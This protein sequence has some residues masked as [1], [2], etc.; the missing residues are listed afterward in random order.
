MGLSF[1]WT[2][3][4]SGYKRTPGALARHLYAD[5]QWLRFTDIGP[6]KIG[7]RSTFLSPSQIAGSYISSPI[8]TIERMAPVREL[9]A[10]EIETLRFVG[11]SINGRI[12][13][14]S[15]DAHDRHKPEMSRAENDINLRPDDT[16]NP[17]EGN[18]HEHH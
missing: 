6:V 3:R 7:R 14:E 17:M 16:T 1:S 5:G 15:S 9:S 18:T 2:G 4:L 10:T 13:P 11:D 8:I 12:L